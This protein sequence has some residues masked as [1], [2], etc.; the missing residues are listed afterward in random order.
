MQGEG[1]E[2]SINQNSRFYPLGIGGYEFP[3][4]PSALLFSLLLDAL[5]FLSAL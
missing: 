4:L 5:L 2:N 1:K 3:F